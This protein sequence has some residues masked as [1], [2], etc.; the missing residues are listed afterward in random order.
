[1][2]TRGYEVVLVAKVTQEILIKVS[3]FIFQTYQK[4]KNSGRRIWALKSSPS[5]KDN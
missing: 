1:M 4:E 2:Y 3:E 5:D